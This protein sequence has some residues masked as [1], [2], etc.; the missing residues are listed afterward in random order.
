MP[1]NNATSLVNVMYIHILFFIA[2]LG[3]FAT[4]AVLKWPMAAYYYYSFGRFKTLLGFKTA[5]PS[6]LY[7]KDYKNLLVII[8]WFHYKFI[9]IEVIYY[10]K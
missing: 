8:Y 4:L 6:E 9:A 1:G 7:D 3:R 2:V 10:L 5:W